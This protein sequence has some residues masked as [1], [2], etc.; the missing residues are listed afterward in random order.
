MYVLPP[1]RF[2]MH[3]W[4]SIPYIDLDSHITIM[5]EGKC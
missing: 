1:V 5:Y 2:K 4:L 3:D